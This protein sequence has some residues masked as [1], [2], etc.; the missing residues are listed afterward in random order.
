MKH[1]AKHLLAWL[2]VALASAGYIVYVLHLEVPPPLR[3]AIETVSR[4]L[5]STA[6]ATLPVVGEPMWVYV[7]RVAT[8][9]FFNNLRVD[10]LSASPFLGALSYPASL[11]FTAWVLKLVA[12]AKFGE[13]WAE[14]AMGVIYMPHTYLELLAYSIAFVEG[15]VATYYLATKKDIP[16]NHVK[17]YAVSLGISLIVLIAAAL[18]EAYEMALHLL[19]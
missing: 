9:I 10:L 13:R 12:T 15:C 8:M 18:V 11:T 7:L 14:V 5:T 16:E 17:T 4:A 3:P 19:A 6:N 1:L 2:L